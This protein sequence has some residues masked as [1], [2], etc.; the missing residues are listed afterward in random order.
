MVIRRAKVQDCHLLSN[1]AYKSKAYWGYTEDFL[2]QC[3]D[4]LTVTK[5]Y[6]EENPV[7]VMESDN[8]IVAFYSFTIHKKKLDTLF[9]DP[10]Y[11]GKG[12]G[13]MIWDHLLTKA[14]ELG[15]S[16]FTLDSD[17]NAEGFYLKMGAK[18][19]GFTTSTV[20]PDR[21]LPLMKVSVFN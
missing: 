15:I 8:K 12:L 18:T 13:R 3:K 7:Y 14:K 6:I 16:E 21:H 19:I 9:I 4:D 17:P 5:E 1:L 10:D 20:F 2:Q 11:I